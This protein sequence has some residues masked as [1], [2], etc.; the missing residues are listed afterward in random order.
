[1]RVD[2]GYQ[3]HRFTDV[4]E[5]YRVQYY[6]VLDLLNEE[7]SR[8]FDQASLALPAAIEDVLVKAINNSDES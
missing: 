1:M 3:P 8:R 7:I 6:D 5:F 4:H 2:G